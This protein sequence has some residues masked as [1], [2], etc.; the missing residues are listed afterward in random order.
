MG[1]CTS[2]N[3]SEK[4]DDKEE[5]YLKLDFNRFSTYQKL[6]NIANN[7]ASCNKSHTYL[8]QQ[9][10][11]IF[12][13]L[14]QRMIASRQ[15]HILKILD[16][17]ENQKK[18]QFMTKL[19]RIDFEFIDSVQKLNYNFQLFHHCYKENQ[20]DA[21]Y[22]NVIQSTNCLDQNFDLIKE[23][24]VGIVLLCGGRSS[25]LPDKLL[26]DIGLPS[27]KCALQIMME[28]LKKILM[29]CN[30]YYLNVQA[31]KN[32]D[33]AHYPIAIVLSDRNSE[34][35]Q[36]YLKYQGDFEFQSIYYIIEKQLPVIDQKGQVVF[37]QENQA[38]M[39]PEGTGS[40]FLQLN[41]F[42]NKFPNMEYLHF[43]GLDNLVGLPLDPQ[44]LN[45]ICKQKADALC[46]VIETN[47]ILDD[48]IFY[49][50][51]QFKT[52]E[53]WDSTITE[54]SYNMTQMLLNDLYLSVSFLNKMKS[55]HEKALK[56]NQRYHCIKRGSNIQFEKHI[57]DI[58][59]VTDITILHQTEDYAL[60]IDDPRR[61]V[62]QLSNVHKRY[63]KLDGTQEEDLVEITPQMSYC[64]EDLKK[65]ENATYPLII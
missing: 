21:F 9:I 56:L 51:K 28:R 1:I 13:S 5:D 25:R 63:L 22:S 37:E 44:M 8:E 17:I 23:Q 39:T 29:L 53:E 11:K 4:L 27:K 65:I 24:K 57:Q 41:S 49:S 38:I 54:N 42:I 60:L 61:A 62:I 2:Q 16:N 40:I 18:Q 14:I 47:S 10:D 33:I 35:I 36:M 32:K 55:N 19:E 43:L 45:L 7:I 58:I 31:S 3:V 26:S 46:K 15:T 50:N 12:S 30:T 59:E 6:E 52:M 64:G 20:T 34:K 48:R